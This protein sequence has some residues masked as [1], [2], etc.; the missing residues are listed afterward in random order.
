MKRYFLLIIITILTAIPGLAQT[1]ETFGDAVRFEKT[2]HDFGTLKL[3]S[4]AVECSF[5]FENISS[6]PMAVY[7]VVT[8][9]G[10]ATID[11]TKEP[12]M[13]NGKGEIRDPVY[14]FELADG[15]VIDTGQL[16]DAVESIFLGRGI[17]PGRQYR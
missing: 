10:C 12:I 11:Y 7:N 8:S 5:G 13:P 17:H 3:G 2:V 9:C 1:G 14:Q 15:R 4:G 16:L 6:S